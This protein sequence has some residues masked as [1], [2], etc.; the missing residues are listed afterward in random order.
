[1]KTIA[2]TAYYSIAVDKTKNRI[3]LTILG[4]WKSPTVVP[5]YVEDMKKACQEI[6]PGFTVLA[7]V[8]RMIT[9]PPEIAAVHESAQQVTLAAGLRKSAEI[10]PKEKALEKMALTKWSTKTGMVKNMF[11]AIA[12]A[13]A[14]L[15]ETP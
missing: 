13:E 6:S 11:H 10:L 1:M 3:Y 14:W 15:D 4:F 7:D 5:A 9:L 8:T 12:D 2:K